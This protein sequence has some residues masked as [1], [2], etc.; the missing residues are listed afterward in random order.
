VSDPIDSPSPDKLEL[1]VDGSRFS[2]QYD[3][4]QPG[5]YHYTRMSGPGVGHGYTARRSD[6][7]RKSLAEHEE[8]VR[9]WLSLLD[10]RTGYA[11]DD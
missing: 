8:S 6:H 3:E 4:S 10:P 7:R 9:H 2:V 5:A 11:A 1:E